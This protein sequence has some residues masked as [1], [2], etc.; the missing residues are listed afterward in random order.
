MA[1]YKPGDV[2]EVVNPKPTGAV[3]EVI[4]GIPPV[5]RV[6]VRWLDHGWGQ[7]GTIGYPR[8]DLVRKVDA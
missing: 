7:V 2:V 4:E 5:G 6:M 1:E 8:L 3:G